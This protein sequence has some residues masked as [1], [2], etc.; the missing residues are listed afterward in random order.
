M[1]LQPTGLG[2]AFVENQPQMFGATFLWNR[3]A[4]PQ[5]FVLTSN[6]YTGNI[7][8][9]D[10]PYTGDSA[11]VYDEDPLFVNPVV[12]STALPN[13]GRLDALI[14][15]FRILRESPAVDRGLDAVSMPGHPNWAPG[16]TDVREDA[17]GRGRPDADVW[18]LGLH[19][20][21]D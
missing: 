19:E 11:S 12:P 7:A 16:S 6:L 10:I 8:S 18:D 17:L 3:D 15:S 13:L 9:S 1:P 20:S 5:P 2:N 21:V 4:T 14:R